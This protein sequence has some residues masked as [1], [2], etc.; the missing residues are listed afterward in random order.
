MNKKMKSILMVA[1]FAVFIAV[2]VFAYD[3]LSEDVGAGETLQ[4]YDESAQAPAGE[5]TAT[6]QAAQEPE[7]S[8]AQESAQEPEAS[9]AQESAQAQAV[10]Q[11]PQQAQ[12]SAAPSD[13]PTKTKAPDFTVQDMQGND[14]KLSDYLGRPV[15]INFWA[16]WCPP[17]K[18][19]MPH[20]EQV[21]QQMG[22]D[23]VFMMI[24]LV[25]GVRETK[26]RATEYV[27][28]EGF[29]FPVYFDADGGA[30]VPYGVMS[31]PTTY[32]IDAEGYLVAGARSA[33]SADDLRRGI[34]MI[35]Q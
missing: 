9:P 24:D 12:A 34:G 13:E 1:A 11:V 2:A 35:T 33:I 15:V 17:C 4:V 32:F 16:S 25:D 7:A 27:Q 21:Y 29:T 5:A 20:F 6:A 8:P 18:V 14:I 22:D 28:G 30:S 26:E 19:E 31:I 23:V 3:R 10:T